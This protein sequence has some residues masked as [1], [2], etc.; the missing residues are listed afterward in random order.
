[1]KEIIN[2]PVSWT[3][4]S[5][6]GT[7]FG[8]FFFGSLHK[9]KKRSGHRVTLEENVPFFIHLLWDF[10]RDFFFNINWKKSLICRKSQLLFPFSSQIISMTLHIQFCCWKVR[11]KLKE[12]FLQFNLQLLKHDFNLQHINSVLARKARKNPLPFHLLHKCKAIIHTAS[13]HP[14]IC[15]YATAV[16]K[17]DTSKHY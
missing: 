9:Q 8:Y 5:E 17:Y 1:M 15:N 11:R 13:F 10:S 12:M 3:D 14:A 2:V 7:T 16:F 4:C 6:H